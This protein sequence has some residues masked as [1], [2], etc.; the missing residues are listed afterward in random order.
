MDLDDLAAVL[1]CVRRGIRDE[2]A[3]LRGTIV[4]LSTTATPYEDEASSG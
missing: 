3:D 4:V 1:D 2:D